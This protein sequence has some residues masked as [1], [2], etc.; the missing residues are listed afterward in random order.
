VE[1][2]DSFGP[3]FFH[4]TAVVG[5]DIYV[6]G[7]QKDSLADIIRSCSSFNAVAKTWREV[8]PMNECR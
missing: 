3:L 6:I 5:F 7:G 8:A 4:G 1:G 2:F